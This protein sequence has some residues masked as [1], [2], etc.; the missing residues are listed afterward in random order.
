MTRVNHETGGRLIRRNA[1]VQEIAIPI[2]VFAALRRAV[3][4]EAGPLVAVR[5]LHE[6][7][8]QVGREGGAGLRA[9]VTDHMGADAFW[10]RLET[11]LRRRGWGTLRHERPHPGVGILRSTDWIEATPEAIDPEGSCAFSTGFLGG[12]LTDLSGASVAVLEVTC[13]TRGDDACRFAFGAEGVIQNLYGRML[14]GA[15]LD[16]ALSEL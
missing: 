5:A 8:Y 15:D 10:G 7:G 16:R 6:A 2:T 1:A 9:E 12:V 3:D 11:F 4:Q 13:R 14:D